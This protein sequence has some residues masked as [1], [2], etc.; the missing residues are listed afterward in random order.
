MKVEDFLKICRDEVRGSEN[1]K[2]FVHE[3][4]KRSKSISNA[5]K[6]YNDY[7]RDNIDISMY[8]IEFNEDIKIEIR[9]KNNTNNNEE[10][11]DKTFQIWRLY[12]L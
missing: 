11:F 7:L 9:V 8:D 6:R 3:M 1:F 2:N 5:I 10:D 4:N 12:T